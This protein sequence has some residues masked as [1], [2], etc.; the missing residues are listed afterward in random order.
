MSALSEIRPKSRQNLIALVRAA[1]V[2]VSDWANLKGGERRS[3]SNPKYCY[4][5]SFV[6]PDE[7]VVLCLWHAQMQERDGTVV[8]ILN[9]REIARRFEQLPNGMLGKRR[10]LSM[11]FAIQTAFREGLPIRVVV[12]EGERRDLDKPSSEIGSRRIEKE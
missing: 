7:V 5:W 12:C 11:D 8:Q 4:E 10:S 2:D 3:P 6:Q 9:M 1:G